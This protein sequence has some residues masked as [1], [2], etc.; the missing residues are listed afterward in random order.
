MTMNRKTFLQSLGLGVVGA[1]A[2]RLLADSWSLPKYQPQQAEKFWSAVREGYEFES[3]L[4]YFNSGGLGPCSR[5][6]KSFTAGIEAELEA[7]VETGHD[8][9]DPVREVVGDFLGATPEEVA[10]VRNATEGNGIVAGGIA[11]EPGDEVIFESHAHP[12]GSFP[13]LLQAE[14]RGVAVRLFEPHPESEVE[15]LAR[16]EALITPRT[17]AVQVSHVTAPTGILL[18]VQAIA[19]LCREKGIWFHV[20]GAQTAGMIPINFAGMGCDSYATSGHKWVGAPR[21]T[22]VLVVKRSRQDDLKSVMVGAYSGDVAE[23][24]GMLDYY[25]SA[26]RYEYGTR[27]VARVLGMAEAMRIQE[28]IGRERIA[29]HGRSLV[30][31]LREGIQSV[32]DIEILSPANPTLGSSM[33]SFRTPRM[34]YRELFSNL[35]RNHHLRC[36]PVSERGLDAVRVSCHMFNTASDVDRLIEAIS[37][38]L[39]S[40]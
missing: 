9:L 5:I 12:G 14:Q 29:A 21:E 26:M 8:R 10:F 11:L 23:L 38:E 22:G 37:Q 34:D 35:W 33:L 32:A 31:Q 17:R 30:G 36:R 24:P 27:D 15:N 20:D 1:G 7:R 4:R 18:P 39:K 16:I 40:V 25:P 28:E 3:Q 6:V 2:T 13:W 19:R